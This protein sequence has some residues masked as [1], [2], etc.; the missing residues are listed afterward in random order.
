[1]RAGGVGTAVLQMC[2][3]I[4]GVT[5]YGTCSASKHAFA[6]EQGADHCIDYRTEDYVAAVKALTDGRGVN[7]V[8][9]ALG[10]KDWRKGYTLLRSGGMLITFGVA[11]VSTGPSRNLFKVARELLRT[12]RH[13]P[14]ALMDDNKGVAGVNMGHMWDEA[15][16]HREAMLA[17]VKMWETGKIK[18][19]VHAEFSFEDADKAHAVLE[20]GR[21]VGKVVLTP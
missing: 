4:G 21:N 9:D 18:P 7:Y 13:S 11:N 12:P 5:T 17:I 15:E 20:E 14:L 2:R 8:L 1:M 3:A 10:P 6:R 16:S 19:H